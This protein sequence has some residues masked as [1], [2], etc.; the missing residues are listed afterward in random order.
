MFISLSRDKETE[1]KKTRLGALPLSTPWVCALFVRGGLKFIVRLL[2]CYSLWLCR[3]LTGLGLYAH[4]REFGGVG[5][6]MTR[7]D[8]AQS[9]K[10]GGFG[11][12]P[13]RRCQAAETNLT[14]SR[15]RNIFWGS[16][17]A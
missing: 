11:L 5:A 13:K 1:P 10:F 14:V 8:N 9:R 7:L 3:F 2:R 16:E 15:Q 17:A 6:T 12:V 4:S